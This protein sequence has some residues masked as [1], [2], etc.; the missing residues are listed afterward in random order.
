MQDMI[1]KLP[2]LAKDAQNETK[3]FFKKIKK[4]PPKHLDYLMQEL[5][6]AEFEKTDCLDCGNCCK[7]ASPIFTDKDIERISKHFKMKIY[8]FTT[9]FLEIDE[10]DFYVLKE[11]PC[12]LL[13]ADNSCSIYN[14]LP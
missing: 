11:A 4:K 9:Q 1:D 13:D 10:D 6:E 8:D 5:H 2:K 3:T 7:T 12:T 14:V